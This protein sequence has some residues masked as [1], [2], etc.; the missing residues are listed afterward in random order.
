MGGGRCTPRALAKARIT[1]Q[2][3]THEPLVQG[4]ARQAPRD[5]RA[6]RGIGSVRPSQLVVGWFGRLF[7][8]ATCQVRSCCSKPAA[9]EPERV[10]GRGGAQYGRQAAVDRLGILRLPPGPGRH[11]RQPVPGGPTD[12]T[13]A[14]PTGSGRAVDPADRRL[15]RILTPVEV[16]QL[17]AALCIHR[18]VVPGRGDADWCRARSAISLISR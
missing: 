17:A 9:G 13:R 4:P 6:L 16:D 3:V 8:W 18:D 1:H 12:A 2:L 5:W 15:P 10:A 7:F 14:Q 11:H